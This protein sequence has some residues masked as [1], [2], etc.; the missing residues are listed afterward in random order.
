MKTL[1]LPENL[2]SARHIR[3]HSHIRTTMKT[4]CKRNASPLAIA[5][6]S[7][8]YPS[9]HALSA[10]QVSRRSSLHTWNGQQEIGWV[11]ER[12]V[13]G[14]DNNIDA[15]A[16]DDDIRKYLEVSVGIHK[17]DA[18]DDDEITTVEIPAS[19]DGG[20]SSSLWPSALAASILL[21]RPKMRQA[22]L[23][24][25][26][27]ELGS[28]L[29][30]AGLVAAS[31]PTKSCTLT[32]KAE[33]ALELLPLTIERNAF[34]ERQVSSRLLDWKD[35]ATYGKGKA[36]IVIGADLAYYFFLLRPLMDASRA[37][38]KDD[39]GLLYIVGQAN[40]E[41]QWDLKNNIENGCYNQITDEREPPWEGDTNML[42]YNL[43]VGEWSGGD[44]TTLN[45]SEIDEEVPIAVCVYCQDEGRLAREILE[46]GIDHIATKE[47]E[48]KQEYTF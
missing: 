36:D 3:A 11:V 6:L 7:V 16:P 41:S 31:A 9:S 23:D 4:Y 29:G 15:A 34:G 43:K 21:R 39:S 38:M 30:L 47:D 46:V 45:A 44:A 33:D 24:K 28:G 18:G 19:G 27:L 40:R 8:W 26:V 2:S 35:E 12:R 17:D 22:L 42:L 32:D 5:Y 14:D 37:S 13:Q 25:D 1:S 20:V 48:E 10:G